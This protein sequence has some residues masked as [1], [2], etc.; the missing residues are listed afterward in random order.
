MTPA[1]DC[2]RIIKYLAAKAALYVSDDNVCWFV[3]LSV[4]LMLTDAYNISD[5]I[6]GAISFGHKIKIIILWENSEFIAGYDSIIH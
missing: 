6:A 1:F 2:S 4:H 3:C 5:L